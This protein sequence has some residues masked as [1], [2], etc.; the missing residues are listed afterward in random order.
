MTVVIEAQE[1]IEVALAAAARD[2]ADGCIVL[3]DESSHADVRFALNTTTT[4]GVR[5]DRTVT[6]IVMV[7]SRSADAPSVGVAR[8]SGVVDV[9]QMVSAALTD[10]ARG[11]ARRRCLHARR[12]HG[13]RQ[14]WWP[15]GVAGL[16]AGAGRDGPL[17]AGRRAVGALLGL[18][19][20]GRP[21]RRPG[22][23]RRVRG[24]DALPGQLDRGA[25][26]LLAAD[27]CHQSRRAIARRCPLGLDRRGRRADRRDLV[28]GHG[29][30]AVAAAGVGPPVRVARRRPLRGHPAAVGR[31]RHDGL[32]VL[33][34][35]GRAGR[36]GRADGVL[37]RGWRWRGGAGGGAVR[38]AEKTRVGDRLTDV[39]F[40]LYSDPFEPGLECLPFVAAGSSDSESS[41]FDN[42][43]PLE[44]TDWIL[45]GILTHLRYHRAGAARS[46]VDPAP[47][48]DNLVLRAGASGSGGA[49]GAGGGGS[50]EVA[51][52]TRWWPG[53]NGASS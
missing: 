40:T 27:R 8:R 11:A 34:R 7:P 36:G 16:R 46:G 15:G 10:A 32:A 13:C 21:R 31:R 48:I 51:R 42:A 49:G 45:D 6:V 50:A 3:V 5:R 28:L 37:G 33:L 20:C 41:V 22:G 43:L 35:H 14:R 52:S 30:R 44:R 53:P 4:N 23:L 29:G 19:P 38:A 1:V 47:Y 24:V 9:E 39:P 18:R 12:R 17:R 26:V 2:G 25:P